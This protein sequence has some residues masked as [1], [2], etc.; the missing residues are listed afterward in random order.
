MYGQWSLFTCFTPTFY[1]MALANTSVKSRLSLTSVSSRDA[2][3]RCTGIDVG[4]Y[5]VSVLH[6]CMH[7]L[8]RARA[9]AHEYIS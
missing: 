9:L 3:D 4:L 1:K 5:P 6:A 7:A 8:T 2:M